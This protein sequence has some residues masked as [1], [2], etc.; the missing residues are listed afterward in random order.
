M[1][2]KRWEYG[3][4]VGILILLSG[5]AYAQY[6]YESITVSDTSVGLTAA[7]YA[8]ST[9]AFIT[10]E[11]ASIRYTLDGVQVPSSTTAV[12]H[13]HPATNGVPLILVNADEI[14]NFKAIRATATDSVIKVTYSSK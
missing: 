1:Q 10:C 13:I 7:T 12:G 3:I 6:K 2:L 8:R 9:K 14:R 5:L 4:V 11:T